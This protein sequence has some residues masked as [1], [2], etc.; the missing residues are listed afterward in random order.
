M[1]DFIVSLPHYFGSFLVVLTLLVFVHEFGHFWVAR[2]CGVRVEVFSIGFGPELFGLTDRHG[3]RWKLSLLP[4][5]GYVR[6]F[7]ESNLAATSEGTS[8]PM[9]AQDQAAT[10]HGKSVWRRAAVVVAGPTANFIFAVLLLSGLNLGYGQ[11]VSAPVVSAVDPLS[12]AAAAGI[13]PGDRIVSLNGQAVDRF[14]DIANA[15]QLGLDAPLTIIV[16]RNGTTVTMSAVPRVVE[17]VDLFGN[18]H[19][20]GRLGIRSTGETQLIRHGPVGALSAAVEETYRISAGTLQ[21]IG[22]MVVGTRSA[23][24]VGGI[25]RIAKMSGD[26]AGEGLAAMLTFAAILSINLGLINLFPVP[27]LDGGH[28][29]Y[30][31]IEAVRGRPL[32]WRAQEWGFRIGVALV[33]SLFLFATRN[34]LKSFPVVADFFRRL[35]T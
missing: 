19:R 21:A 5:G 13:L 23:E 27:M 14:E 26:V 8:A 9:S 3:T 18:R 11:L 34:D 1:L 7:G 16:D 28:L 12:A 15:V 29:V 22:Q 6:M 32:G 20:I 33:A 31:V 4:L 17:E 2:R 24:E 30:Y 35:F 10:F 25:I